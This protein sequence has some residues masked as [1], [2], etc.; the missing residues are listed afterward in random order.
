MQSDTTNELAVEVYGLQK[1]FGAGCCGGRG[2]FGTCWCAACRETRS[3][4]FAVNSSWCWLQQQHPW[5]FSDLLP[6]CTRTQLLLCQ[7]GQAGP[8]QRRRRVCCDP[9]Q[10]VWSGARPRLL[11]AGAQWGWQEYNFE[12]FD[13]QAVFGVVQQACLRGWQCAVRP[14]TLQHGSGPISPCSKCTTLPLR[15]PPHAG[16]L[17]PSGGDALVYGESIGTPGGMDRIRALMG[18][19][20]QF[21]VLWPE[22]TGR[23]HLHLFGRIK[24]NWRQGG[25]WVGQAGGS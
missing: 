15:A 4:C 9:G 24:V 11:P 18:V 2:C 6:F 10:L 22:L 8:A 12:L 13:R 7:E 16:V 23:E 3:A 5:P 17:P 19:C 14:P 1:V 21:D 25:G 20:P